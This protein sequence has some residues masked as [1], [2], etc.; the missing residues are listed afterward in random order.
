MNSE[1]LNNLNDDS[2]RLFQLLK[3]TAD[4]LNPFHKFGSGNMETLKA[5]PHL[6]IDT[7][8]ALIKVVFV[9]VGVIAGK[10]L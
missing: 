4:P 2:W 1:F 6:G 5:R 10:K 3:S 9:V 8:E 7:R